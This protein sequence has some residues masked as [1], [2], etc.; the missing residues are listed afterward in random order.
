MSRAKLRRVGLGFIA[1]FLA[2]LTFHQGG[3]GAHRC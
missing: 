2:V 3:D 1:G